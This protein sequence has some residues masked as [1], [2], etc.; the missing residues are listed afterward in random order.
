MP[1]N[2]ESISRLAWVLDDSVLLALSQA[3]RSRR[4]TARLFWLMS[5][6]CFLF[7]LL[8]EVV[9][10][11][12]VK[13]LP[14]QVGVSGRGLHLED[15]VVDRQDGHVE[16]APA[17]IKDEHVA[18]PL[19]R[20]VQPV[21]DGGGRGLVDDPQHVQPRDHARVL[22]GLALRVVEVG[23][24]GD[25][26]VGHRV[27]QVRLGDL[28]HLRQHHGRDLLR[29]ERL[30]LPLVAHLHLG[31]V[32]VVDHP[33]RPVLH[34]RLHHRVAELAADQPLRVKHGVLR[35]QR[36]L[37][38]GRIPDQPLGVREGHVAGGGAVALV[39]GDDLHLA[40]LEHPH[41][42]VGGAQVDADGRALSHAG[43]LL[44]RLELKRWPEN[45]GRVPRRGAGFSLKPEA[46]GALSP[47][48]VLGGSGSAEAALTDKPQKLS[49]LCRLAVSPRPAALCL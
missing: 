43:A 23:R 18:L 48:L 20:P 12:V 38:L 35:V 11:P 30:G 41:A 27:A 31:L 34:V 32:P 37:V 44:S 39:V 10:Q 21:G 26:R 24:H 42:R 22:G 25:H 40:V 3:V 4:L 7:E 13:V 46:E 45:G 29:V 9:H 47:L 8:H 1:S 49:P 16:G 5:F 28:L 17:Q 15:A 33:E 19:A 14:T 6:L 36:H 2:R